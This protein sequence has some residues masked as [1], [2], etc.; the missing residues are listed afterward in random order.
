[1]SALRV[2]TRK[3][4]LALIQ[5]RE[6]M[7]RLP[8]AIFE[9]LPLDSPGDRDKERSLLAGAPE[10]FFTRDLDLALLE[11]RADAA[12]HSAKDLPYP[13]PEGLVL[14]ALT[15]CLDSRDALASRDKRKLDELPAGAKVG[16]SSASR[17]KE[18]GALRPD[19]EFV[20]I[21]GTIG[22][23][24][25]KID[26]GEID[27][28]VVA[29]CALKRLGLENRIAEPLPFQTHPLQGHLAV[30]VKRGR[31]E[32]LALFA[33]ID[34]RRKFG[35][36]F[37]LGAGPG[38]GDLIT[39][40]AKKIL[41]MCD[42]VVH[43][44]LLDQ[45]LLDGVTDELFDAGKRAGSHSMKQGEICALLYL[46]AS[47]GK[48]VARLQGGDPSIFGRSAEEIRY[49]GERLVPVEIVPG[50]TA[51]TAAA[52]DTLVSLTQRGVSP[53][54]TFLTAHSASE[55]E[56]IPLKAS[57][58][59]YYMGA[60]RLASLSERLL[61]EGWAQET[62]CLLVRN[63]GLPDES[64]EKRALEDLGASLLPSPLVV[65]VGKAVRDYRTPPRVLYTG[66][67]VTHIHREVPAKLVHVPFISVRALPNR[68]PW[69]EVRADAVFIAS[70]SAARFFFARYLECDAD[71]LAMGAETARAIA[72]L[73]RAVNHVSPFPESEAAAEW[74]KSLSY[75]S[76]LYPCSSLSDNAL[77]R[78]PNVRALRL[79]ETVPTVPT[80]QPKPDLGGYDG[81]F[82]SS[83]STVRAFFAHYGELP[84]HLAAWAQGKHTANELAKNGVEDGRII[85]VSTLP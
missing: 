81:V 22:E 33:P 30:M 26:D 11:G 55:G 83:P 65:T 78:L 77:H 47:E 48:N 79:Y 28:L 7:D 67:E 52:A 56:S 38:S 37:L 58:L 8:G 41:G 51:A 19:L 73:G 42:A 84:P 1:M 80:V 32:L 66:I 6:V 72:S 57:T 23:R 54:A 39:L 70:R 3:S 85:D 27:A 9:T 46:L 5:A 17:R 15:D 82:F 68:P 36:V 20:S 2:A 44:A 74:L 35:R 31:P 69:G 10:D 76:V 12:V 63:A 61:S 71:I 16:V 49:L 60:N 13:L 64:A 25:S 24:L 62:P 21:R 50:V 59:V 14:A 53:G 40:R 45:A 29:A 75:A 34:A 43:D 18:I 4:P